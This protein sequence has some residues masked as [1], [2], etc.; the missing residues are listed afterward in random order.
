MDDEVIIIKGCRRFCDYSGYLFSFEF[1][2]AFTPP[3]PPQD[4]IAIDAV[5]VSHF[6][7]TQTIRD[8]NKAFLGF[9][10]CAG[11][12]NKISTGFW[13]CGAFGGDKIHKFLQQ[14]CCSTV[15]N[16]TLYFS[17]YSDSA[18]CDQL[19]SI[20]QEIQD[21]RATVTDIFNLMI[22]FNQTTSF[23]IFFKTELTKLKET[24]RVT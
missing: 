16:T 8:L 22:S 20:L 21:A 5:Y 4:I 14:L 12:R 19:K 13:G 17:S 15:T 3:L 7:E 24:N 9:L 1:T 2:K 23:P 10:Q 18:M 11:D 6:R